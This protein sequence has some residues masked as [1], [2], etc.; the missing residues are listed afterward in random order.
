[1]ET[2]RVA[3]LDA[4]FASYD[5][6]WADEF[7]AD[8]QSKVPHAQRV[9]GVK[10]HNQKMRECGRLARTDRFLLVDADNIIRPGLLDQ[11]FDEAEVSRAI[12]SFRGRNVVN[13]LEYGNGGPTVWPRAEALSLVSHEAAASGPALVEYC[14]SAPVY[15]VQYV[16]SDV[17]IAQTPYHAFRAGYRESVKL[18]LI[19]GMKLDDLAEVRARTRENTWRRVLMW[20][21]VGRD[22]PGGDWAIFGFRQGLAD[23]WID[24]TPIEVINDYAWFDDYWRKVA[25]VDPIRTA[26][27]LGAQLNERFDVGFVDLDPSASRWAKS[28]FL[29]VSRHGL[30]APDEG[31]QACATVLAAT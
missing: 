10:G 29:N 5:E 24:Q 14:W 30:R 8:L 1:L 28:V 21:S 16:G 23:V 31:D 2:F 9:H 27:Q 25:A 7:F 22:V 20:A 12:L 13:G 3:D 6:P 26:E 18:T 15:V 11:T 4:I 19:D 17:H